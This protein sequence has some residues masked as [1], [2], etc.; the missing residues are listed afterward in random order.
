MKLS[1]PKEFSKVRIQPSKVIINANVVPYTE[2]RYI[3]PI[4]SLN[5][6][7]GYSVKFIPEKVSVSYRVSIENYNRIT[8]KDFRVLVDF[9][10]I[11]NNVTYVYPRV[12]SSPDFVSHVRV[13]PDKVDFLFVK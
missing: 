4:R 2:G 8:E 13:T 10:N 6:P 1:L 7:N 3:V 5:V 11:G 12:S 9:K